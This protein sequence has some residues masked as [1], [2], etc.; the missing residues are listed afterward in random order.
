MK[1]ELRSL[2][3]NKIAWP[4]LALGVLCLLLLFNFLLRLVLIPLEVAGRLVTL[5]SYVKEALRT[6]LWM[7]R[8]FGRGLGWLWGLV[9]GA[10]KW[11]GLEN[12]GIRFFLR[13]R[14]HSDDIDRSTWS[15][16]WSW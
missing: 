12:V 11:L 9:C 2:A 13:F 10:V 8:A 1:T 5:I 6:V 4:L 15:T 7:L 16:P 3:E 14:N